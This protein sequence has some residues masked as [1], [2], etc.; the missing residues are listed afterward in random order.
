LRRRA[1]ARTSPGARG[2]KRR[3]RSAGV[4][5]ARPRTVVGIDEAG[6]GAWLGPLVVGAVAVPRER[7]ADVVASGARD[8]KTLSPTRREA[9][10]E[11]LL[12]CASAR[13]VEASPA[14]VDRHV[15]DGRLN[16]L[17]AAL[18]GELARGFAPAEA[19]VD[20]CDANARRFG[21]S[22]ARHAGPTV[23]VRAHHHADAND[24][25]V[26]A[27]SIV[28][29]VRRDRAIRALAERLGEAIGSGYPSDPTTVAFVRRTVRPGEPRPAWLRSSWATTRRVIGGE[30]PRAAEAPA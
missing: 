17:E 26:G 28:A 11:R 1:A 9:I 30:P 29:K 22:V 18:F 16:E 24:P 27:A 13:S 4:L 5:G 23:V 3:A 2:L 8:S 14:Q 21:T 7:L 19:R 12:S 25:L 15:R 20:A 6:R 10:L